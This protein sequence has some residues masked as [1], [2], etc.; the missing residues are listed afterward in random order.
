VHISGARD[1]SAN[2]T[3]NWVR[4]TRVSGGWQDA[5]DVPLNETAE[6]Y[7]VEIMDGGDVV[8]TITGL[9]TPSASYSAAEQTADFGS[10]QSSVA[11]K[12]Y[13]LSGAVGR[14]YAGEATI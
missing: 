5:V 8:R 6:A 13:Q 3:I 12:I 14:G 1:G 10:A 9:T 7:E 11:V 2:L 4:R